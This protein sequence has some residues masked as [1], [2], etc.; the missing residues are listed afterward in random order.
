VTLGT[1]YREPGPLGVRHGMV[2]E[3]ERPASITFHQP[4]TLKSGLGTVDVVMRYAL[5]PRGASTV[6][7]RVVTV[8]IPRR[9]RLVTPVL[10][11]AFR[12][13]SARTL[14]ALKA[15]AD[16]LPGGA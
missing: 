3:L 5:A 6:V 11:F 10:R 13:E 1:T 7:S 9:L 4:M 2:T 8:G 15:Y 14:R 16:T 12:R